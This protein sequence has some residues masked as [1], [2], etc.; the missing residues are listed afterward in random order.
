MA[1]LY[2]SLHDALGRDQGGSVLHVTEGI[3]L[4]TSYGAALEGFLLRG[5]VGLRPAR[6]TVLVTSVQSPSPMRSNPIVNHLYP[7]GTLVY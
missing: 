3:G 4:T 6:S 2:P 1:Q 7:A 5:W